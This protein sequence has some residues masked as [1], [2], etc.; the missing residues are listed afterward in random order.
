VAGIKSVERLTIT[1]AAGTAS[2]S[3]N[4]TKSQTIANCV[5][6]M[7]KRITTVASPVDNW[8]QQDVDI[9][10][11]TGPDRV[12]AQTNDGS[13]RAIV[14]E[15]TVREYDS[16]KVKVQSGTFSMTASETSPGTAPSLTAVVIANS[17]AV[18]YYD[19]GNTANTNDGSV[20]RVRIDSTTTLAIDR[21]AA[22]GTIDGHWFV[23]ESLD[24]D[25]TVQQIDI[26]LSAVASNTGTL[27][28]LTM[29]KTW[30]LFTYTAASTNDDNSLGSVEGVLTSSTVYTIQRAGSSGTIVATVFAISFAGGGAETAQ[31]GQIAAQGSTASENVDITATDLDL[32]GVHSPG[33]GSF[34][35]G[36]SFPGAGSSD[37]ADAQCAWD[38]VDTDTIRVQHST[39]GGEASNDLSW[40]VLE[41]EIV[42]STLDQEGYRW[43][44]DDG[45]ESAASWRQ[46]QDVVDTVAQETNIRL[47]AIID[48]STSGGD[49]DAETF[50][51]EY[52]ETADGAAEW[53]KVPV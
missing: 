28:S 27:T 36:G 12:T 1:L 29:N 19:T 17:A 44:D 40:E 10:F 53:R 2:A 4:L 48:E 32:A 51:L 38:F 8:A 11:E 22:S 39:N 3:A 52:K 35:T 37:N 9:F 14:V 26:T 24:G 6:L 43:R 42:T 15:V 5:P 20:C 25:F 49:A 47:R 34:K 50:Q 7:T 45:S 31:R 41:D 46:S 13:T 21:G 33:Y 23:W 30:T 18:I 16:A